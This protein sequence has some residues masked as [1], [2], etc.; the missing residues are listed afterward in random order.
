MQYPQ[1]IPQQERWQE[2]CAQAVVEA[3]PETFDRLIEQLLAVLQ[4]RE[5]R[6]KQVYAAH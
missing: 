5:E 1:Q 6:L 4:E 3:N 2:L